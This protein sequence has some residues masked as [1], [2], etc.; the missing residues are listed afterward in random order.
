[1]DGQTDPLPVVLC[2]LNNDTHESG[3]FTHE[4]KENSVGLEYSADKEQKSSS[5]ELIFFVFL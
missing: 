4:L 3:C 1:M 2:L 5:F